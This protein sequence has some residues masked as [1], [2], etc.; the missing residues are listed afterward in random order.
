MDYKKLV[1]VYGELEKTSAR[2]KKI[3]I[4]SGLL[5]GTR[6]ELLPKVTLLVQGKLFPAWSESEIGIANLLMVK[7]IST[8]TGFPEKDVNA[9]FRKTGDFGLVAEEL[10]RRKRQRTL[11]QKPLT[12][13]KVFGNLRELASVEGKGSQE[14]KFHLVS[15]L[16]SSA[17]PEEARYIV[18]TVLGDLRIGVAEGVVRD[19]IAKA[20][21]PGEDPKEA[22][23]AVEWAWFLRPDYGEIACI[24]KGRGLPGL[25]NVRLELGKAYH[26][27]L[28]EKSPGLEGHLRHLSIPP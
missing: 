6:E 28:S 1:T 13:E 15:E 21:L 14:R 19:S 24:A 12:V 25:K 7:I 10:I 26:V 5:A 17:K 23:K 27:L 9:R 20:F 2:L 22:V 11:F 4:I 18:R 3:E 16:L 8:A